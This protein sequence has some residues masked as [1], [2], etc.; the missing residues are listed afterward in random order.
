MDCWKHKLDSLTFKKVDNYKETKLMKKALI[1]LFWRPCGSILLLLTYLNVGLFVY[2]NHL[3]IHYFVIIIASV[4]ISGFEA[5]TRKFCTK[6]VMML[7]NKLWNQHFF[8]YYFSCRLGTKIIWHCHNRINWQFSTFFACIKSAGNFKIFNYCGKIL[9]VF[10]LSTLETQFFN[11][12]RFEYICV[13]RTYFFLILG[14]C[15]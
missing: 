2:K 15:W 7:C 14:Q 6:I 12:N 9:K 1:S 4:H 13:M 5:F 10:E 8:A 3:N 11:E